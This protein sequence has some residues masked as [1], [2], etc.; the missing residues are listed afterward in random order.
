MTDHTGPPGPHRDRPPLAYPALRPSPFE[1]P[2]RYVQLREAG[3]LGR[4]RMPY[5][6]EAWLVTRLA[7]ARAILLDSATFSS[8]R[9]KPGY[10]VSFNAQSP[11]DARRALGTRTPWLVGEDPPEHTRERRSIVGE[12]TLRRMEALRPRVQQIT[13]D[14]IDAM[15]M[16]GPP[17]DLVQALCLPMP[18]RAF[19]ELL[20]VPYEDHELIE[21]NTGLLIGM[22]TLPETRRLS[23]QTLTD[24][25]SHLV[26]A[27][28]DEPGD[29]LL[30]R[31]LARYRE[32]D[33]PGRE[34][35]PHQAYVLLIAGYESTAKQISAGTLAL[36]EHPALL[37]AVRADPGRTPS[38]VEELLRFT[39]VVE[40]GVRRVATLDV[41]IGGVQ[42][43]KD[44]AVIIHIPS[45]NRDP[46][47]FADPDVLDLGR[48]PRGHITFGFG[49]HQCLGQNLARMELQIAF[50][51]ILAR[52]PG[53]RLDVATAELTVGDNALIYGLA[54]LPVSW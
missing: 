44:D 28:E 12:F 46:H 33:A 9:R 22:N 24:Y 27:K 39:S 3:P 48:E 30:S 53:L 54:R 17:A 25:L 50:D 8:D 23:T 29:D 38:A 35:L 26:A 13:D 41:E 10:P 5:G 49:P 7:E 15:L 14:L 40:D 32:T 21:R 20:G 52:I 36:L 18:L 2:D 31:Q 4:V 42:I 1:L 34:T 51:T 45:A 16:S 43:R 47:A 6:G 11:A 37:A 19:C